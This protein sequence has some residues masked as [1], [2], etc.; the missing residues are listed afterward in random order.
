M[1]EADQSRHTVVTGEDE[2]GDTAEGIELLVSLIMQIDNVT[3][4]HRD[5]HANNT[6]LWG[7]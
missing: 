1:A 7:D 2:R 3:T 6:Y 5:F 4:G